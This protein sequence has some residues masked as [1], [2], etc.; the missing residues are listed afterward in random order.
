MHLSYIVG[1]IIGPLT[2]KL[3]NQ[4]GTDAT[5]A[6]GAVAFYFNI[7]SLVPP[8]IAESSTCHYFRWI[9]PHPFGV[10]SKP[11][12]LGSDFCCCFFDQKLKGYPQELN[13]KKKRIEM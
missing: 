5:I 1:I 2:G 12:S 13:N 11:V 8:C 6:L 7:E 10:S 4:I 9:T 3:T